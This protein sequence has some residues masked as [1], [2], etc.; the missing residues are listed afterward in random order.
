MFYRPLVAFSSSILLTD[1]FEAIW[2]KL[3]IHL[4][5]YNPTLVFTS[6]RDGSTLSAMLKS[7]GA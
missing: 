5:L 6:E 4:R 7:A 2:G 3:G 1:D